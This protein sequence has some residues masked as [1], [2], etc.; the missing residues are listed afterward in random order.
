ME[1]LYHFR[2]YFNGSVF[3]G[4][5]L[6]LLTVLIMLR[7][8]GFDWPYLIF[9]ALF[10]M[11]AIVLV[12]M[13]VFSGILFRPITW[14]DRLAMVPAV[15]ARVN[16]VPFSFG[17]G[18]PSFYANASMFLNLVMTAPLGF[19]L[20]LLKTIRLTRMVLIALLVGLGFELAQLVLTLYAASPTRGI[21][22]TDVILNG[23]GVLMGY[24]LFR[25]FARLY[26]GVI[27]R[28]QVKP[29]GLFAYLYEVSR[30]A[31]TAG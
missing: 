27:G 1:W 31:N 25:V 15:L 24:G 22:I 29:K 28:L 30:N 7:R 23:L 6:L 9:L 3:V 5:L 19:G 21:D 18:V 12:S 16:L 8:K 13:V 14:E 2:Y 20:N 4:G 11:Y 17:G 10:W 26:V